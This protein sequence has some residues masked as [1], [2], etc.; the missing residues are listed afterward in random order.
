MAPDIA[1]LRRH[2]SHTAVAPGAAVTERILLRRDVRI[3]RPHRISP[4]VRRCFG[5]RGLRWPPRNGLDE[6]LS[7]GASGTV[8]WAW[9]IANSPKATMMPSTERRKTMRFIAMA[10]RRGIVTT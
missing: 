2:R 9:A 5:H 6:P 1:A 10:A 8:R 7:G 3:D 4:L